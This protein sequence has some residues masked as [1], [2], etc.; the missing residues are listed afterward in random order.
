MRH[1]STSD[2]V[3][4]DD[5]VVRD[6]DDVDV[7]ITVIAGPADGQGEEAF[8]L[9]VRTPGSL[10]EELDQWGPL[11]GRHTVVVATWDPHQIRS[12]IDRLFTQAEGAGLARGRRAA[13]Q[14]RALGVRGL[15]ALTVL[16]EAALGARKDV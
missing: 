4:L 14:A 11:H 7:W 2:G 6:P 15:P 13:Q 12:F 1:I 9:R 8:Q 10:T 3:D 5:V 16:P